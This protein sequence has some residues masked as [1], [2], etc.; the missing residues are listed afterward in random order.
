L[1]GTTV[2]DKGA[3]VQHMLRAVLGD[4]TFSLALR[5]WYELNRD[6]AGN[7]AGY[8]AT[9]E[10]RYGAPLDWFFD[11]WVYGLNQPHYQFGF[12]TANLGN[13]TY[14]TWVRIVQTQTDAGTFT[15]PVE[16]TFYGGLQPTR[17]TVWNDAADQYFTVDTTISPGTVVFDERDWILKRDLSAVTIT[18]P[19]GDGDGVPDGPD[20]CPNV[21]NPAQ[22]DADLDQIGDACEGDDDGDLLPDEEDCAPSDPTQGEPGEVAALS[23]EANESGA[24]VIA[25]SAATGAEGYVV[26]RS[27]VGTLPGA[28]SCLVTV[29]ADAT[30]WT[31]AT[32]ILPP[33]QAVYYLVGG[34]DDGC[35]GLGPLGHASDGTARSANCN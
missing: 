24:A 20:N 6:G 31:D 2:Y 32:L 10:A 35:G 17:H 4:E 22:A 21:A 19:D 25:W 5:D 27:P 23:V 33:G 12:R 18:L 13:G 26:V 1:F 16:L 8:R 29:P 34:R 15:M 30:A 28:G 9:L 3:W 14:R 7:T 11:Q